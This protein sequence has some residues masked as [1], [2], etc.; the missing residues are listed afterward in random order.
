MKTWYLKLHRWVALLFAAPLAVVI[1]TGLVLSVEPGLVDR[2]IEP[3][4]LTLAKVQT[5]LDRYDPDGRVR[6]LSFRSFDRTL[7]FGAGFGGGTTVN[8]DSG[9]QVAGPSTLARVL[10]TA[11]RMHETLL[12]DAGWLVT[13]STVAMLVLCGLGVLMGWPRIRNNLSGWHKAIAWGTLPLIVLSL[14][15]APL[16]T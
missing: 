9:E 3:G 15:T 14:L 10:G 5:L 8:V 7:S 16:M 6:A 1:V 11:R 4:S 12:L 13:A 2:A